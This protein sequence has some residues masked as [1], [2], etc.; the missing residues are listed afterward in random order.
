M[1]EQMSKESTP[2]TLN[3]LFRCLKFDFCVFVCWVHQVPRAVLKIVTTRIGQGKRW[4]GKRQGQKTTSTGRN[5]PQIRCQT[6][7]SVN[8]IKEAFYG[9]TVGCDMVKFAGQHVK[10]PVIQTS[11]C[12]RILEVHA[13]TPGPILINFKV[14]LSSRLAHDVCWVELVKTKAMTE[15]I[16]EVEAQREKFGITPPWGRNSNRY[17]AACAV[18]LMVSFS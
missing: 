13:V 12:P 4:Q 5:E 17:V 14:F 16:A 9:V 10:F 7:L 8:K 2:L 1:R 15:Y 6:R 11:K 3:G 18:H